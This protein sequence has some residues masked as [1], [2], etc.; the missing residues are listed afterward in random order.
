MRTDVFGD[1]TVHGSF[2]STNSMVFQ[3]TY[4]ERVHVSQEQDMVIQEEARVPKITGLDAEDVSATPTSTLTLDAGQ[5][6]SDHASWH[7]WLHHSCWPGS[8][9]ASARPQTE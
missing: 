5:G 7:E 4:S 3:D 1:L 2:V 6:G 8:L 9:A